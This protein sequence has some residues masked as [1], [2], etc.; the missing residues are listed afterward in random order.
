MNIHNV[1]F[2]IS[3][4]N[5]NQYPKTDINEIAM[6]G[7]SNVG[8]SSLINKIL[9]R[10]NFARVSSKPGKTITINFY[11]IDNSLGI[12]DLPGYGYAKVSKKE[13]DTWG[14]MINTY[15]EE[16]SNLKLIFLLVDSRHKPS[17]DDKMMLEWVKYYKHNFYVIATKVDKLKPSVREETLSM[18]FDELDIP[19]ERFIPFSAENGEGRDE[20]LEIFNEYAK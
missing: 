1:N 18:C 16:R 13:K 20:I 5:K 3:A 6:V 15:L 19:K 2:I 4:V 8:K 17:E 7:R 9:N 10:K 12:V 14:S 11:N